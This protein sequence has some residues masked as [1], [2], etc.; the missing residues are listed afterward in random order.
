MLL[1]GPIAAKVMAADFRVDDEHVLAAV[2]NH[3]LG[4][5]EMSLLAKVILLAD[6]VEAV[7]RRGQVELQAIR[8]VARRDLDLALLC[9]ADR[10]LLLERCDGWPSD[11][12]HWQTRTAWVDAHHALFRNMAV[13]QALPTE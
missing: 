3:T 8:R 5:G 6:K 10:K 12:R 1:H 2:R 13:V 7:K 11:S 4:L 9:W